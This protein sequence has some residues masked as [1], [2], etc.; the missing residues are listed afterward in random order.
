[1]KSKC[2]DECD[3]SGYNSYVECIN[4]SLQEDFF[5]RKVNKNSV[6]EFGGT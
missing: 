3:W 4:R 6:L 5:Y 1:M 2:E